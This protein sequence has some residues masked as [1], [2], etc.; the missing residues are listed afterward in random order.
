LATVDKDFKVKH[1]LQVNN[2]GSFGGAV[3]VG[4]P[5]LDDHAATKAYVDAQN[6][7][8]TIP[9]S[10]EAPE[11]PS[12]GQLYFDSLTQRLVVYYD[13]T[14]IPIATMADASVLQQH[15]HD[16]SI[17][18]NGLI[19]SIFEDAGYFD[20]AGSY[21]DAGQAS[22]SSWTSYYDGGLAIDNFN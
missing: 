19:V 2:G 12:N 16:T 11:S 22:T 9:V 18:G 17:D 20:S 21:V 13:S 14:W 15:I 6:A 10:S 3:V 5:T 7:A 1:G 4:T 8:A